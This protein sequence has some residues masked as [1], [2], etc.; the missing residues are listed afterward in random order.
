MKVVP[1]ALFGAV[2]VGW[3]SSPAVA[4]SDQ[5]RSGSA[6][7]DR[8]GCGVKVCQTDAVEARKADCSAHEHGGTCSCSA[9]IASGAALKAP[10]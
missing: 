6:R 7:T 1:S 2:L 4:F 3:M 10:Q 9:C 5:A 8:K